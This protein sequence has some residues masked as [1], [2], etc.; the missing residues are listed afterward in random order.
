[1]NSTDTHIGPEAAHDILSAERPR[2]GRYAHDV[3]D[4]RQ[5]LSGADLKGRAS[6]F[7][8]S[9]RRARLAAVDAIEQAGGHIRRDPSRHGR[10][11]VEWGEIPNGARSDRC[12]VGDCW[13]Y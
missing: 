3:I 9:Y 10:L 6:S 12:A 8:P 7:G 13:V 5:R 11:S 2:L 1:M 4:G